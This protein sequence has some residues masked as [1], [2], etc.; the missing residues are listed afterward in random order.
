MIWNHLYLVDAS[1]PSN[2]D[3]N[4]IVN[5]KWEIFWLPHTPINFSLF[6]ERYVHF[7]NSWKMQPLFR[8]TMVIKPPWIN[9]SSMHLHKWH[10]PIPFLFLL[11]KSSQVNA[12]LH[13]MGHIKKNY[14][15]GN[16]NFHNVEHQ[17]KSTTIFKFIIIS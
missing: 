14:L 7:S 13:K 12:M 1:I 10:L 9:V 5:T 11:W 15:I 4:P 2:N 6:S 8:V 17:I 16:L 3:H